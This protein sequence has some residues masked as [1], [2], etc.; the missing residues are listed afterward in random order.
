MSQLLGRAACNAWWLALGLVVVS[1]AVIA[2]SIVTSHETAPV[3]WF[4]LF[5]EA[6]P[7]EHV[8]WTVLA[9]TALVAMAASG[10]C[11]AI[12]QPIGRFWMW[13][14][15]GAT[16]LLLED[17]VNVSHSVAGMLEPIV[18]DNVHAGRLPIYLLLA[19]L[20]LSP[21]LVY[22][23]HVA[24]S[25]ALRPLL[26][27]VV[28]YGVASSMSIVA[29]LLFDGY[30]RIGWFLFD[31]V[32]RGRVPPLPFEVW[33]VAEDITPIVFMDTVVEEAVEL[34]A[35]GFLLT[36]A[37]RAL[38]PLTI[39]ANGRAADRAT[40]PERPTAPDRASLDDGPPVRSPEIEEVS[41]HREDV[42]DEPSAR[43][44]R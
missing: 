37:A 13:F 11:L 22:R 3:L 5:Q 25:P 1:W 40:G 28:L 26:A 12:G 24:A 29:N 39:A 14:S 9:A 38:L 43:R 41:S 42:V 8:Q 27:G 44:G 17:A 35:A 16:V 33:G 15:I 6:G 32:F 20:L 36:A 2:L 7:V 10:R 4:W 31:E 23:R 30:A 21:L 34:V 18:G 19:V